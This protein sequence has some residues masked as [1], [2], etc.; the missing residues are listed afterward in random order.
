M[1]NKPWWNKK[2]GKDKLCYITHS[3]LRPTTKNNHILKLNCGHTFYKKPITQWLS[4][5]NSC[6]VCRKIIIP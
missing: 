1:N 2:W 4:L 3:R 5:N 6:P